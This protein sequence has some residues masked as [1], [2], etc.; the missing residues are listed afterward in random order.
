MRLESVGVEGSGNSWSLKILF[1][2]AK[3]LMIQ[4][5]TSMCFR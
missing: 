5:W 4:I 3:G 1:L 2:Q